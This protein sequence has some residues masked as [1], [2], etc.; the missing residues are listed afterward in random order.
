MKPGMSEPL[1][2]SLELAFCISITLRT[3]VVVKVFQKAAEAQ[4]C[5]SQVLQA[6]SYTALTLKLLILCDHPSGFHKKSK[7]IKSKPT[8]YLLKHFSKVKNTETV[9]NRGIQKWY[10]E[11][12]I[13]IKTMRHRRA[14]EY[15][16]PSSGINPFLT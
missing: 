12:L 7:K 14:G 16:N 4:S 2:K 10:T 9:Y 5:Y 8:L 3:S 13:T 15:E 6:K 11:P 1:Q